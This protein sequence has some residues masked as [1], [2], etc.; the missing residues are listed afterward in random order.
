MIDVLDGLREEPKYCVWNTAGKRCNLRLSDKR[1]FWNGSQ[2]LSCMVDEALRVS[3][4]SQLGA[5]IYCL[6]KQ[7]DTRNP[8]LTRIK[9]YSDSTSILS[10]AR[11]VQGPLHAAIPN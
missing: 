4:S 11:G 5:S 9:C 2:D 10:M 6:L 3:K 1:C 7:H 8:T